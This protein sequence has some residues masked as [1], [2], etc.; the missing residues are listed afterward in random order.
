MLYGIDIGIELRFVGINLEKI[1][2]VGRNVV[3]K[4]SLSNGRDAVVY[5]PKPCIDSIISKECK[6]GSRRLEQEFM[7]AHRIKSRYVVEFI[8]L[9]DLLPP[10]KVL[11]KQYVDSTLRDLIRQRKLCFSKVVEF[12]KNIAIA[13]NDIHR[14]GFVYADLKPENIGVNR[15][16]EAVLMDLDSLTPPYTK[17]NSITYD[18]IPPEYLRDNIVVYESDVYQLALTVLESLFDEIMNP[19]FV[20]DVKATGNRKL[21]NLLNSMLNS[22]PFL[23]PKV[24]NVI[25]ELESILDFS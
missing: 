23:R 24:D 15:Y 12:A 21:D 2:A 6:E 11:V 19:L 7:Y 8:D 4:A 14:A 25:R 9:L 10:M 20:K 1:L 18:Y 16:G 22:I 17:P 13:I 5:V 3:L